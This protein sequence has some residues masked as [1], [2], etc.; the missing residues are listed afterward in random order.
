M[1]VI[2]MGG[3]GFISGAVV[4]QLHERGHDLLLFHRRQ[5]TGSK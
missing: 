3:T 5:S 1:R 2:V 4:I